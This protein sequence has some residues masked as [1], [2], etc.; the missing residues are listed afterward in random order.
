MTRLGRDT[1]RYAFKDKHGKGMF[2]MKERGA[3]SDEKPSSSP[4]KQILLVSPIILSKSHSNS[5]WIHYT[6]TVGLLPVH[7][8][9]NYTGC[10]SIVKLPKILNFYLS[11]SSYIF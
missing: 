1:K 3:L 7:D 5:N 9:R 4:G 2:S 8:Y 10:V 11:S 6:G